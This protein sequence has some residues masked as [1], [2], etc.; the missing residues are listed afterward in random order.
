MPLM[1]RPMRPNTTAI[2]IRPF[3]TWLKATTNI[4]KAETPKSSHR[5][6]IGPRH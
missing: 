1:T 4:A 5:N 3:A 2:P 6:V